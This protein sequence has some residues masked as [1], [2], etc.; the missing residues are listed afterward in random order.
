MITLVLRWYTR[1]GSSKGTAAE[2]VIWMHKKEEIKQL[3]ANNGDWTHLSRV[4]PDPF[5]RRGAQLLP[6]AALAVLQKVLRLKIKD[7]FQ[8]ENTSYEHFIPGRLQCKDNPVEHHSL[9][10]DCISVLSKDKTEMQ[11]QLSQG[12]CTWHAFS[13]RTT[14]LTKRL[15]PVVEWVVPTT[16]T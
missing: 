7:M 4:L 1:G 11:A 9:R 12:H 2:D 10:Y 5:D 13:P 14:D 6:C 3:Q 16:S 8:C 15:T